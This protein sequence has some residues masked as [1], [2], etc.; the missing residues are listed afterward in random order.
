M[1]PPFTGKGMRERTSGNVGDVV[2]GCQS[3]RLM[4]ILIR[5]GLLHRNPQFNFD[6]TFSLE[7]GYQNRKSCVSISWPLVLPGYAATL[8]FASD[9]PSRDSQTD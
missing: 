8:A 5:S 2:S 3:S 9:F 4:L 7:Q 1:T 6:R